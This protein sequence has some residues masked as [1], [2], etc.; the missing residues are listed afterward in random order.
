LRPASPRGTGAAVAQPAERRP[1][2]AEQVLDLLYRARRMVEPGSSGLPVISLHSGLLQS[3]R[4]WLVEKERVE[5]RT[6][7]DYVS[8]LERLGYLDEEKALEALSNDKAYKAARKLIR[9]LY[10]TGRIG[11]ETMERYLALLKRRSSS[12]VSS[13]V[14]IDWAELVSAMK[15]ILPRLKPAQQAVLH[16]LYYSGARVDEAL[17][18]LAEYDPSRLEILANG[19]A[20]YGLFWRRGRKRC[21]YIY[22]PSS[23]ARA[24]EEHAGTAIGYKTFTRRLTRDFG[25]ESSRLRKLH[26]QVCRRVLDRDVCEFYHSR[27][28][29]LRV[30]DLAYE[31]L[32][33][34]ADASYPLLLRV[35][36]EGLERPEKLREL[37]RRP[38]R[39]AAL[40]YVDYQL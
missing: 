28:G 23:L 36:E 4:R 18:L 12:E 37:Q 3:F 27:L 19:A 1:G 29:S 2:K 9:Y 14:E 22:F 10:E 38:P 32:R 34:L 30:G 6:A 5:E 20:R 11:R 24:L 39:R 7:G 26:R 13:R 15:D 17:K 35:L 21:D 33:Q 40:P 16:I 31:N 8:A 25:F